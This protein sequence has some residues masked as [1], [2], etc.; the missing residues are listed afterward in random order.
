V[1]R[2]GQMEIDNQDFEKLLNYLAVHRQEDSVTELMAWCFEKDPACALRFFRAIAPK[3]KRLDNLKNRAAKVVFYSQKT[4]IPVPKRKN[5][6]P[7]NIRPDLVGI[8]YDNRDKPLAHLVIECKIGATLGD[9][10]KYRYLK[11]IKNNYFFFLCPEYRLKDLQAAG[12]KTKLDYLYRFILYR[13]FANVFRKSRHEPIREIVKFIESFEDDDSGD[14]ALINESRVYLKPAGENTL[15]QPKLFD[16]LLRR[17]LDKGRDFKAY[18]QSSST[19]SDTAILY[20]SS[21]LKK[22]PPKGQLK[23]KFFSLSTEDE[24]GL[25]FGHKLYGR[26]LSEGTPV[27]CPDYYE[28]ENTSLFYLDKKYQANSKELR[29]DEEKLYGLALLLQHFESHL[30]EHDAYKLKR[31][32]KFD[33]Q[34]G[35]SF[36][37]RNGSAWGFVVSF[38]VT[39]PLLLAC[40]QKNLDETFSKKAAGL[41]LAPETEYGKTQ[42]GHRFKYYKY[43]NLKDIDKNYLK[44]LRAFEALN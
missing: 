19:G 33:P 30:A 15:D 10:K 16:S 41:N 34:H 24:I 4:F 35:F 42:K 6:K 27:D 37:I 22:R 21:Y 23:V 11:T 9:K 38:H 18:Y 17:V 13:E 26:V 32:W 5:K 28:K 31:G 25:S 39:G 2:K 43:K 7:V 20:F 14:E 3:Y 40:V 1:S 36:F 12:E 44:T 8:V 29:K